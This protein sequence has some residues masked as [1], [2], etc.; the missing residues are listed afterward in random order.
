MEL[1]D[2]KSSRRKAF[3]AGVL[4]GLASPLM[5]YSSFSLPASAV[6][7]VQHVPNPAKGTDGLRGDWRRVGQHLK[8][9]FEAEAR[10][11]G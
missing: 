5:V 11:H 7:V 4:R 8:D 1:V 2:L 9:S 3:A 6:P 10:K